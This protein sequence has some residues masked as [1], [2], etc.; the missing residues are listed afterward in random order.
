ML[1]IKRRSR[2]RLLAKVLA[3]WFVVAV[4]ASPIV[5]RWLRGNHEDS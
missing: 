5:G 4:V 3:V 1:P 2:M